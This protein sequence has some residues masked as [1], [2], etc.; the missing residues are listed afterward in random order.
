[1]RLLVTG[2]AGFIGY[3]LSAFCKKM[4]L[5][6][7][8]YDNFSPYYDISLK[9]NREKALYQQGIVVHH[10][11]IRNTQFLKKIV[12]SEKITHIVHLAA[13]AGV[14]H[15][16]S[17]P[18]D[19]V[20][21]NLEGFV[22]ILEAARS[23]P[24]TKVI[25]ASSSS[26]YGLNK[27][28]PFEES[29]TTDKPANFYGAT[30]KAGEMMAFSYHY[31]YDIPLIGL[32]FFTVYGPWGRPDMAYYSFTNA[33]LEEKPIYVRN[34]GQMQRDFTY[35]DDIILGAYAALYQDVGFEIFNL[36]NHKP[37]A[38]MHFISELEKQ[39]GKKAILEILPFEK[40]EVDSTFADI[41]KSR[42]MLGF[43][44]KTTLA[45]GLEKFIS[46]HRHYHKQER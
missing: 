4:G 32:R 20:S 12:E 8:G 22:S 36:G 10:A 16:I 34:N 14:R 13:Q 44:P 2:A 23:K 45:T 33:I 38:L 3:H 30:K 40:G 21:A 46:W 27:K 9:Q 43:S 42:R 11:D 37:I 7:I 29:D 39:L 19:Y 6:V 26:V 24:K 41:S 28:V 35:I 25:F 31:L 5:H 18:E 15:S 17:H 1:M